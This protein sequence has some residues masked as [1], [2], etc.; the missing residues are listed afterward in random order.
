VILA[1][2]TLADAEGMDYQASLLDYEPRRGKL[3][4]TMCKLRLSAK[5]TLLV[6]LHKGN[7]TLVG[8]AYAPITWWQS[9]T[10]KWG[11]DRHIDVMC[12][13]KATWWILGLLPPVNITPDQTP[14]TVAPPNCWRTSTNIH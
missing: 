4:R 6:R 9:I 1:S 3:S 14:S 7:C 10:W 11:L 13:A 5:A 12:R 8:C 2:S